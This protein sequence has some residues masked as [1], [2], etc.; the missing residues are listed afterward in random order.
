M[1]VALVLARDRFRAPTDPPSLLRLLRFVP[2]YLAAVLA[3]GFAAL[4]ARAR[5]S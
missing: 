5:P 3:F 1:V 4:Y 2:V